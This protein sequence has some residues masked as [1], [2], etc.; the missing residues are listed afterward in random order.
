MK[1]RSAFAA[2]TA[3]WVLA[4][5]DSAAAAQKTAS[6]APASTSWVS[7]AGRFQ[8]LLCDNADAIPGTGP[9]T[10]E[11]CASGDWSTFVNAETATGAS[12]LVKELGSGTI[13]VSIWACAFDP[14]TGE[15]PGGVDPAAA[16]T[17]SNPSP[18]CVRLASG[19]DGT[20][21]TNNGGDLVQVGP[22]WA[23]PWIGVRIDTCTGNCDGPINLYLR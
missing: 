9:T 21:A 12:V 4:W 18:I 16:P 3:L 10:G 19:V 11:V 1:A 15:A 6:Y 13:S 7:G 17:S 2:L 8:L 14:R 23:L 20:D 5:G 22:D